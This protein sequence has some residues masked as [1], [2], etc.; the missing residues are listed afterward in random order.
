MQ[1]LCLLSVIIASIIIPARAA[2]AKNPRLGL[3]K[4][5]V[6]MA[7]FNLVYVFLLYFVWGRL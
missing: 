3:K 5:L 7:I 6:N 1:K 2:R 4:T